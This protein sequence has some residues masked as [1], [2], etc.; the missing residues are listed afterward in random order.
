MLQLTRA[1]QEAIDREYCRRSLANF[2]KRAW[3][4]FDPQ[5]YEHNWHMDA[6]GKH[7]EACITGDISRLLINV[8][9]GTTKSTLTCVILP[10]FLWGPFGW[11]E[12]KFIGASYEQGLA[13]R[14]NRKTRILV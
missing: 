14:D 9:P 6:I 10:A 3:P 4:N 13:N 2:A 12:A 11:P 7:L 5:P 8:P 1:D